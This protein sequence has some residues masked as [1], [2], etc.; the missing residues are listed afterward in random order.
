MTGLI[1]IAW[2][3]VF[4]GF[5][6]NA[7]IAAE[8][9]SA[10]VTTQVPVQGDLPKILCAYGTA[11]ASTNGA[12]TLSLPVEGRVMRVLATAGESV[13]AGQALLEFERSAAATSAYRQAMS[14]LQLA[15]GEQTRMTRMLV[16]Q[17][18]TRDQ[19]AQAD[20][21]VADAQ[22]ALDALKIETG[23]TARQTLAAP[24]DGV[25]GALAIA[26]GDRVAAGAPLLTL[27]RTSGVVVTVGIEPADRSKVEPGQPVQVQPL[28]DAAI[29][30]DGR[31]VRIDHSLNPKSRLI[32]VDVAVTDELLLGDAFRAD[33]AIGQLHGWIAPRDAVLDDD[34]GAH[35]YQITDTKAVRIGVKRLGDADGKTVFEGPLD[36]ARPLVIAGNYELADGMRVREKPSDGA[37]T[38]DGAAKPARDD[39]GSPQR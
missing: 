26:Q 21:A 24:F 34:A 4:A 39:R 37:D 8:E 18:A 23:G 13:H 11:V 12:M 30:H 27:V 25:V 32:D 31:V 7:A 28:S 1:K 35:V 14:A 6:C 17:T 22:S 36:V 9:S 20:K 3:A 2:V 38:D 33:I 16:Q 15:L 29:R 5:V 19:K 10:E